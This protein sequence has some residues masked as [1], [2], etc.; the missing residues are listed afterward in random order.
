MGGYGFDWNI[1]RDEICVANLIPLAN[2]GKA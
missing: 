2:G 1:S